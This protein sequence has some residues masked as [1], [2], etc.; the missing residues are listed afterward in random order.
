MC[1]KKQLI[2]SVF[3]NVWRMFCSHCFVLLKEFALV[4]SDKELRQ[5]LGF[6]FGISRIGHHRIKA[7]RF[8]MFLFTHWTRYI[9][10]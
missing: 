8:C 9:K 7:L 1:K 2:I 3:A 10:I 6:G 5:C 4:Y